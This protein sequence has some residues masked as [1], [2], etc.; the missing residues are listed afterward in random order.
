M[1][2]YLVTDTVTG[3]SW[4]V[5]LQEAARITHMREEEILWAIEAHGV[6]ETDRHTVRDTTA[7]DVFDL[8]QLTALVG[9]EA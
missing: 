7:A 1:R 9:A 3:Q 4:I 5:T 8:N 6:C 2:N